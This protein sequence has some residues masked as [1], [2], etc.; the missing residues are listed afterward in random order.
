[1]LYHPSSTI[2]G[3]HCIFP[4]RNWNAEGWREVNK[5]TKYGWRTFKKLNF[6]FLQF[7]YFHIF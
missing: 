7:L 5:V 4:I 6:W 2:H 3:L 1:L